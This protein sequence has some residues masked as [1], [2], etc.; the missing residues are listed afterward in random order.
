M[1]YESE[2]RKGIYLWIIVLILIVITLNAAPVKKFGLFRAVTT[3]TSN[4]LYPF[5][6]T[7]LVFYNVVTSGTSNFIKLRGIQKENEQLKQEL[8]E[9]K[10]KNLLLSELEKENQKL[11]EMLNFRSKYFGAK[12]LPAEV[13]GRSGSNWFEIIEIN[14]GSLDNVI[15]DTAVINKEGLVGRIFEVSGFSSKV[16]LITDPAS[17]VSVIDAETGDMGILTGNSLRPLT[18]KYMSANA[19]VKVGDKIITSG[20]SEIFPKGIIVGEVKSINKKVYDIFQKVEVSPAVNFSKL[21]K[22]FVI[23]RQAK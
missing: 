4:V 11:K 23:A 3:L 10:A 15:T 1:Y 14:R 17:A 22:V 7:G 9:Y 2:K 5:K 12:L 16:L 20:M 18:I 8:G 13:I 6:Y 21:D 19:M